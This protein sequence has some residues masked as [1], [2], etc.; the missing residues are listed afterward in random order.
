[1]TSRTEAVDFVSFNAFLYAFRI[2]CF[3]TWVLVTVLLF[4]VG[5]AIT[6]ESMK[7]VTGYNFY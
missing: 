3:L 6:L 5:T 1:M 7:F 4:R 2:N